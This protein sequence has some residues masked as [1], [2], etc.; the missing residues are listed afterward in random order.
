LCTFGSASFGVFYDSGKEQNR[1][2]GSYINICSNGTDFYVGDTSDGASI[3][4]HQAAARALAGASP[5]KFG[6]KGW[7]NY[8][9]VPLGKC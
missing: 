5:L 6:T 9:S 4:R 2:R 8:Y 1:V 7:I 3:R